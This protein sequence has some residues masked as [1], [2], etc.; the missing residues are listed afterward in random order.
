MTTAT[1]RRV[2]IVF[3][4]F[5]PLQTGGGERVYGRIAELLTAGGIE[6]VYLTR[7]TWPDGEPPQTD[8]AV[9]S[10]WQGEIY[11]ADG[12]RI[13]ANA[14]K[15]ALAVFRH[16]RRNRHSYD[17]AIVSA[18]PVL[19]I[20]A[21][22]LA[23]FGS[24]TALVVDWME[25]WSWR[26]WRQ[27]SGALMGTVATILQ[28]IAAHLGEAL[29]V[30]SLN[31]RARLLKAGGRSEPI[32][33]GLVDLIGVDASAGTSRPAAPYVLFVGR[34][35][36]DKQLDRLPAA[37]AI[38]RRTLPDLRA[39]IAGTGPETDRVREAAARHGVEDAI[40][41]LGRVTDENL[42][43]EYRSAAVLVNPS[44]REGFGLVIAEAA[45]E[46]TPSVVVAGED[47]AAT[48][49][50]VE[51]VNGHVADDASADVLG[52]AIVQAVSAGEP[53]R[54]STLDWFLREREERGL[55]SS[56]ARL[57]DQIGLA[58]AR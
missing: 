15:F 49:L 52:A 53:M 44:I 38:A 34:H 36:A 17:A 27:Y 9:Q 31:T 50:I 7:Q 2:A 39:H 20:F 33:L 1:G 56:V 48:D 6:V 4:C 26:K 45:S 3:D 42:I 41:F 51:G 35:I 58:T 12:I 30:N 5:F 32:V 43:A 18:T 16:F 19:N 37:L 25:L 54:R 8:Y 55:A 13:P 40:D 14:A 11:D 46:G 47:N 21:A 29:T 22:W 23:L 28:N 57:A 10:I 24:G